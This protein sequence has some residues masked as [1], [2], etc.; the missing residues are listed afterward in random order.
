[1]TVVGVVADVK[2]R[3]NSD[4]PRSLLFTTWPDWLSDGNLIVRTS[5]DP[6]LPASAIRHEINRLDSNLPLG[7]IETMGQV[8]QESL[9][10]ERFRTW[11]L[12]CFAVAALLLA[13]LGIGGLLAHNAAQ[14]IQEFGVRIALGANHSDLLLMVFQH[15]L[16]LSGAGIAIG[17]AASIA[18]TR[19]FSTL[20]Y[21]TSALDP[22]TFLAVALILVVVAFGAALLPAWRVVRT[23][24]MTALRAE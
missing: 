2:A 12:A 4:S 6:L 16:R 24:P 7:K 21:D 20:L 1:L 13:T 3:L 11:L 17:L 9:S 14:R 15:C 5:G 19:A 22:G 18:V 10:A 23:D 8:L